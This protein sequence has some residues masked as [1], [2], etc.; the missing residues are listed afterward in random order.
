MMRAPDRSRARWLHQVITNLLSNAL[1]FIPS[2]G[3]VTI[4]TR[5]AGPDPVSCPRRVATPR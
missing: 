3:Q 1:R 4:I 5:Q 2:G